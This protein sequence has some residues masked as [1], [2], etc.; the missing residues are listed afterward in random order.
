M[1]ESKGNSLIDGY[2]QRLEEDGK[3]REKGILFVTDLV[4]PCLR[5][6]YHNITVDTPPNVESLRIFASGNLIEDFWVQGILKNNK[7]IKLLNTQLPT[8]YI[9]PDK[10]IEVHGRIDALC[11]INNKELCVREVKSI[12]NFYYLNGPKQDH[13]QQIQFYLGCLGIE[14]GSIDYLSKENL[15]QGLDI[16]DRCF[17][18]RRDPEVFEYM[19]KR[20]EELTTLVASNEIPPAC[21]CWS[22]WK[23]C[24]DSECEF[25]G[26]KV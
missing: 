8:R 9:D 14:N 2:L 24:D 16:I 21:Q 12:K 7:E 6:V 4:K 13:Y 26:L 11:Q 18:V 25:H 22:C 3:T 5:N 10:G 19:I 20:A 17:P 23:W 15:L 1:D